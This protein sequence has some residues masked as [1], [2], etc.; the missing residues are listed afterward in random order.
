[1]PKKFDRNQ[2]AL[3]VIEQKLQQRCQQAQ[4]LVCVGLDSSYQR[5]PAKFKSQ[6][7][8]QFK[9]NQSIIEQT[10][11]C[12]CAYKPNLA[13]YEERGAAGWQELKLTAA[14]LQQHHPDIV[15]IADAKR[16]DVGSTNHSYVRAIFDELDF[17]AV[18]LNPY[19]GR[20][21]LQPFLHRADKACIILC[22]TSNSGAG[23]F[24]DWP[25]QDR[26]LWQHVAQQVAAE[27]N[28]K[29]NCMLV[30]GAT[31]PQELAQIRQIVGAMTLLVPGVGKQGG[32]I[33]AVLKAGLNQAGQGVII[34]S[35]RSIIFADDPGQAAA[36]LQQKINNERNL[37]LG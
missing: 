31:Y 29:Q 6:D 22:R 26:P 16:A 11:G 2:A 5:L 20:E 19:L 37:I 7:Q 28:Q 23:E 35:S 1:M 9:F 30:A 10:H 36:D 27:W 34:N 4:S 12:V 25:S 13:F 18:T 32:D 8:P 3:G 17:D 21:A 33:Q 14:Y 24:Q 15:L